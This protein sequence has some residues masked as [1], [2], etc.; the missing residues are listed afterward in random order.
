MP[1]QHE[2]GSDRPTNS[3]PGA[4]SPRAGQDLASRQK[5]PGVNP[6][7]STGD[8]SQPPN[9]IESTLTGDSR[10]VDSKTPAAVSGVERRTDCSRQRSQRTGAASRKN[11]AILKGWSAELVGRPEPRGA[12]ESHSRAS[13]RRTRTPASRR[14]ES[15]SRGLCAKTISN[16]F[17]SRCWVGAGL[18][19]REQ[20]LF[21]GVVNR[22]YE[23]RDRLANI[24]A[25]RNTG[26]R[27]R[28]QGRF[29]PPGT[30]LTQQ[31]PSPA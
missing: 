14:S 7:P 24:D 21:T 23:R 25:V 9:P 4:S 31:R 5:A 10:R 13:R 28:V 16:P 2:R 27:R 30:F 18:T 12:L 15:R 3:A 20:V 6:S 29:R 26:S 11:P 22:S 8:S 19:L 17:A 1:S